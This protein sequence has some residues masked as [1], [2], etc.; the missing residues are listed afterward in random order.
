ME[1][2]YEGLDYRYLPDDYLEKN[3]PRG[4]G[5]VKWQPFATMPEQ[6]QRVK[7]MMS[8]NAKIPEPSLENAQRVEVEEA[9]RRNEG[10]MIIVRYWSNGMEEIIECNL[11]YIDNAS[12]V[13]LCRKDDALIQIDFNHIYEVLDFGGLFDIEI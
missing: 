4:R 8:N 9:L 1:C 12:K 2:S 5:M 13:V 3:I 7:E 11:E 10:S 6:F